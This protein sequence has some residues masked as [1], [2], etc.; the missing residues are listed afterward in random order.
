[1]RILDL[2]RNPVKA[3]AKFDYKGFEVSMTTLTL[4]PEIAVYTGNKHLCSFATA[5]EAIEYIDDLRNN[6]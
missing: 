5:Q 3:C 6:T 2:Y 1:M 4:Y